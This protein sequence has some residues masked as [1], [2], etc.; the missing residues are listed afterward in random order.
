MAATTPTATT[1]TTDTTTDTTVVKMTTTTLLPIQVHE[2]GVVGSIPVVLLLL[3]EE[4]CE[5][6]KWV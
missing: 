1:T 6:L 3:L 4:V 2:I 5:R